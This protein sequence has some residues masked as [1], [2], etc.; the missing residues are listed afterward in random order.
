MPVRASFLI[1]M[2]DAYLTC[3]QFASE[4]GI[5]TK[6]STTT[7]SARSNVT[8]GLLGGSNNTVCNMNSE[9]MPANVLAAKVTV[10]ATTL[11]CLSSSDA[12]SVRAYF[13]ATTSDGQTIYESPSITTIARGKSATLSGF[14]VEVSPL[15]DPNWY[16]R[17]DACARSQGDH[18]IGRDLEAVMNGSGFNIT[19]K[20]VQISL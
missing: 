19:V 9:S 5:T 14:E 7:A 18:A 8:V 2:A 16:I 10:T 12:A 6:S 13:R 11:T 1:L 20:Y 4:S 17:V 3:P 15:S